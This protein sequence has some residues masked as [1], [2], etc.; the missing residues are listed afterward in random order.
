[1][2]EPNSV[3]ARMARGVR[4]RIP[5][6]PARRAFSTVDSSSAILAAIRALFTISQLLT[7]LGVLA[8]LILV[9]VA[10]ASSYVRADASGLTIRNGL[11]RHQ[12]PWSRVHK[13][14]LRSG[15][16]W[17]LLLSMGEAVVGRRHWWPTTDDSVGGA[18]L[19]AMVPEQ[20]ATTGR[21]DTRPQTF[22][23]AGMHLL[24]SRP[25]DGPEIWCRTDDGPHFTRH[26]AVVTN[27]KIDWPAGSYSKGTMV[28]AGAGP[29]GKRG[30]R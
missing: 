13:I 7:L 20:R 26:K 19:G 23:D 17:A 2:C 8:V 25:E 22:P 4:G 30:T 21:P 29:L 1:M 11:R 14:L 6:Q 18:L 9:I 5:P 3:R 24:R 12:V 16:P 27:L 10:A 15:D 28:L